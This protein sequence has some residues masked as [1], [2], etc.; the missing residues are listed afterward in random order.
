LGCR[1]YRASDV[2]GHPG[3]HLDEAP[4]EVDADRHEEHLEVPGGRLVAELVEL[5]GLALGHVLDVVAAG[6]VA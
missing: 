6:A 4:A 3:A 1:P 2:V 5:L